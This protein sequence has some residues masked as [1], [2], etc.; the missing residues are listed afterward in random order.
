ME[1]IIVTKPI[2]PTFWEND[3]WIYEIAVDKLTNR[4][5]YICVFS[6]AYFI[7]VGYKRAKVAA[8]I[9]AARDL[10]GKLLI[11]ER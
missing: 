8:S 9:Q 3:Y 2:V 1:N 10:A 5:L 7:I 4:S 11:S 6:A